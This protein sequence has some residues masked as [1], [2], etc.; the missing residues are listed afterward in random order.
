MLNLTILAAST[1]HVKVSKGN[2]LAVGYTSVSIALGTLIVILAY[3]P[4]LPASEA[5]Q[6]VEEGT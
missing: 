5:H 2:Q 4:H 6:A 1:Y 3:I